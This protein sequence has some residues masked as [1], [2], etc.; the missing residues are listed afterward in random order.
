MHAINFSFLEQKEEYIFDYVARQASGSV[1]YKSGDSV[2]LATIAVDSDSI[3]EEDFLPLTVQYIEKTYA[4]GKFPGGYVK[5]E[6]KPGD[7]ETLTAR[8]VDRSL[9]PLFPKD[10]CY[11]TQ[12]TIMV[13]S[14]ETQADLQL[15]ALNAASAALY[16]SEIP[17]SFPVNGVR[18]GRIGKEFVINPSLKEMEQSTLDLFV[19]GVNEDLLMIEMRTFNTEFSANELTEAE[20]MQ[21]L[22]LAK[23]HISKK[24]KLMAESFAECVK[25]PLEL[26]QMRK[27][28]QCA[29]VQDFIAQGYLGALRAIIAHLSKTERHSRLKAF[30]RK[31]VQDYTQSNPQD[32]ESLEERVWEALEAQKR[33][34]L[35][36]MVLEE[37]VRADGR[38]LKEVRPIHIETNILPNAHSSA[39][40]T[41]G[42]TQALVVCTLGGEMDAQSYEL[43]TDKGASKERFMV[44]YNFPPFSV[45]EASPIGATGR[46]ELGH[47]NLAKRALECSVV[48]GEQKTIRL[49]SEILESNGSSS[50]AT[51]CGGS[52]ALAAADIECTSLIAGVA[53][54]LVCEGDKYAIL[55]DIMGLEDHDGD[56]DFKVAG[57]RNGITALQMDIK[58]GGLSTEI[59]ECALL[60]A[61]EAR[62]HILEIMEQAK[63][64]IVLNTAVL[65]SSQ[66]FAIHPSKI[67]EVIGQAG[68]TIK[69]II[70]KFEVAIDLNRD[71][72]EVKIS[73]GNKEKV[74]AAKDYIIGIV[75][76][77][78]EKPNIAMLYKVGDVYEGR[79]KKVVEFG[80]FVELPHNY[81]GLLHISK[82]TS[83]RNAQASD[84]LCEGD[85]LRVEVLS[86]NKNKVELGLQEKLSK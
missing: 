32:I 67:V 7:F 83:S 35:R 72:G 40:F 20:L 26:S 78:S 43:L 17:L 54:G 9:R 46:R 68:K 76:S 2:L 27:K 24:S 80:A 51:I 13:L 73:G 52:L 44:H 60:Q 42:Q 1:Y 12:I 71:N 33:Q 82:I 86:L 4:A 65:P 34:M 3:V 85:V 28:Y 37:G 74:C 64:N 22:E 5:R 14:A 23:A 31:I 58:L 77:N 18:I 57:S 79:V 48:N 50:M 41:R 15:L 66:T 30:A 56:M 75:N 49:V 69:E 16:T 29:R 55:T 45:G 53:M 39:L 61:K 21:A 36:A 47:G 11:P 10:Y 63:E 19:S 25:T 62:L 6:A 59:L 8:I 84:Y 70:E 38:T 81:D